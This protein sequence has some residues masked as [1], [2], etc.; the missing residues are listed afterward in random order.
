MMS[1]IAVF[2]IMENDFGLLNRS[3]FYD[4]LLETTFECPVF[5]NTFTIFV[6]G[7]GTDALKLSSC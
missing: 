7:C 6:K 4:N 2:N 1:F 5:L 3:G